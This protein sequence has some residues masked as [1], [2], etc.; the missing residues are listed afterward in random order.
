MHTL[1]EKGRG[2]E[3]EK[4]DGRKEG[5]TRGK[6][7]EGKGK[8][9][10]K[11]RKGEGERTEGRGREEGEGRRGNG[12]GKMR[13]KGWRRKENAKGRG[14]ERGE[15]GGRPSTC[16]RASPSHD[17]LLSIFPAEL[18]SKENFSS[19]RHPLPRPPVIVSATRPLVRSDVPGARHCFVFAGE[20]RRFFPIVV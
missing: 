19:A 7:E 9:K 18:K 14:R 2:R 1:R 4:R 8:R 12:K 5:K 6:R 11:G 13:E 10:E 17:S 3:R 15:R 20:R 16:S